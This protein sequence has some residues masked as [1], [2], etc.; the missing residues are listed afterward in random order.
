MF[1]VV[2]VDTRRFPLIVMDFQAGKITDEDFRRSLDA[3]EAALRCGQKTFQVTDLSGITD[4]P[5][6]QRKI[7]GQWTERTF[8]LQRQWSLGGAVVA[9]NPFLRGIITAV[10]WLKQPPAPTRVCATREE[11]LAHARAV[12]AEAGFPIGMDSRLPGAGPLFR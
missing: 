10:H 12:L 4:A 5:P 6:S 9:G 7:A 2:R 11:A 3:C 1:G 8:E